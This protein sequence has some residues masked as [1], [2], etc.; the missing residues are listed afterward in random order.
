[1][2]RFFHA[3]CALRAAASSSVAISAAPD[4]GNSTM[5]TKR[6]PP[7]DTA[8]RGTVKLGSCIMTGDFPRLKPAKLGPTERSPV[9]LGSP[10]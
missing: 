2:C 1:L 10:S 9:S 7:A 6:I 3:G 4:E 5:A 8:D